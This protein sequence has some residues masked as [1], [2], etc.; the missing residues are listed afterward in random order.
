MG[1]TYERLCADI[2]ALSEKYRF[3][4]VS[5]I[6]RSLV[7]RSI[8]LISIGEGEKNVLFVGTHHGLESVTS[9]IL[10]KYAAEYCRAAE[11][12]RTVAGIDASLLFRM[13][14]VFIVPM[15]NPDGTELAVNGHD[16]RNPLT[17]RL[18]AMSGGD[19][20]RWQANGRGVDLNHNYNAGFEEYK[21]LEPT[22][23]ITGGGPTRFSGDHP[24][25]E[26]ETSALCSFI[27]ASD[28]SLLMA[29]HTQGG[30][31]YADYGGHI[32]RGGKIIANR[33]SAL[34]GYRVAKPER[35]ASYGGLKDWFINEY[36]RP[37]FT[38][39]CGYGKNPLPESDAG[40]IY[41]GIRRGLILFPAMGGRGGQE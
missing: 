28:I 4:T 30:E 25:S 26:P 39:E 33:L 10:M 40:V 37:G 20:S 19:F 2:T 18:N 16:D 27:R 1:Y 21:K 7:G 3:V 6:G 32:P 12:C 13:R 24:E 11:A 36:D 5:S 29:L 41:A 9:L 17:E 31:I 8:P 35:S 38:L 23:G 34:T 22:L 15:L 14:R